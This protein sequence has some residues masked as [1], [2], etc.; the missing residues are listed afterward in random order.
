V[1]V[2]GEIASVMESL[3]SRGVWVAV[4]A[5]IMSLALFAST[6][7]SGF[8]AFGVSLGFGI[9]LGRHRFERRTA[10]W[11]AVAAAILVAF[12][13]SYVRFEPLLERAEET[14]AVGTGGRPQIWSDTLTMI[15]DFWLGGTGLGNY[16]S[17]MLIYQ[18]TDRLTYVNQAHNQYLQILAEGGV[19]VVVPIALA[20]IAFIRLFVIRL[21]RDRSPS[22]WL[23]VGA[24]SAM[25]AVG[26][27][28]FWETGL[29]MP[30]NGILFAV[31]A[32]IAVHRPA[33]R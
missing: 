25:I 31:I 16:Q 33:T 29:R 11:L 24:V 10:V 6:S 26:V 23:R 4:S 19:L 22:F 1:G 5:A 7:R 3:G 32:A 17:A 15:N 28:G 13:F 18:Q 21:N 2:A 14:L 9:V 12:L 27:Q 8:I 20:V 30:A